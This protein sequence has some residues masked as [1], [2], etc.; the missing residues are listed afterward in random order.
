MGPMA[1]FSVIAR[2]EIKMQN[3]ASGSSAFSAE[4][5]LQ[6][7]V[8]VCQ[9]PITSVRRWLSHSSATSRA[10]NHP[11][12]KQETVHAGIGK[13][14]LWLTPHGFLNTWA[15]TALRVSDRMRKVSAG[16]TRA[17]GSAPPILQT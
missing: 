2:L 5:V 1:L 15:E 4:E 12:G 3:E 13:H 17:A 11:H 7:Q 10:T 8:S 14:L 6:N 16:M 9:R